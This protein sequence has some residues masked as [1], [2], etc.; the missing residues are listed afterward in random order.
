MGLRK[1]T[2]L[3]FSFNRQYKWQRYLHFL[4]TVAPKKIAKEWGFV[5]LPI[6]FSALTANIN[7]KCTFILYVLYR[8]FEGALNGINTS[9]E[10]CVHC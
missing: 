3:F 10:V 7:G 1:S 4:F 9:G 5:N 2:H 8:R 6:Y